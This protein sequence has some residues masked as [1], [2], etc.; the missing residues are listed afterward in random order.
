MVLFY[1]LLAE[2]GFKWMCFAPLA[3]YTC[4]FSGMSSLLIPASILFALFTPAAVYWTHQGLV[5]F[6]YSS[7]CLCRLICQLKH[8]MK[9]GRGSSGILSKRRPLLPDSAVGFLRQRN[10]RLS[11]TMLLLVLSRSLARALFF[12]MVWY[13]QGLPVEKWKYTRIMHFVEWR[14]VLLHFL[15][16]TLELHWIAFSTLCNVWST[17]C[18]VEPSA[19]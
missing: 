17:S 13:L 6:Q 14:K 5:S 19:Y 2:L 16:D 9:R 15:N 1:F 7:V 18:S 11:W 8:Y 10:Q 4:G 12:F 3:F